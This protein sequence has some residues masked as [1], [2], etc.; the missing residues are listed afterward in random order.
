MVTWMCGIAPVSKVSESFS[1]TGLCLVNLRER[2]VSG[3][4]SVKREV[5]RECGLRIFDAPYAE[6]L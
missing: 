6:R 3:G 1:A 2:T 5:T 4:V